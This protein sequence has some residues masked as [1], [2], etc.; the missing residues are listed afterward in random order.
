[1]YNLKFPN[2]VAPE[3]VIG[4]ETIIEEGTIILKGFFVKFGG[5]LFFYFDGFP[6]LLS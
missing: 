2:Y 3:A 6:L 1:M 4:A 5:N